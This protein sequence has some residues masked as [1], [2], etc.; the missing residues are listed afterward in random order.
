MLGNTPHK[1]PSQKTNIIA[2]PDHQSTL[3]PVQD[4]R[5][6]MNNIHQAE[7]FLKSGLNESAIPLLNFL[8]DIKIIQLKSSL[9]SRVLFNLGTAYLNIKK[10]N[11]AY[12]KFMSAHHLSPTIAAQSKAAMCLRALGGPRKACEHFKKSYENNQNIDALLGLSCCLSALKNFEK[13]SLVLRTALKIE[14]KNTI[15]LHMLVPL[16]HKV[17]A[18]RVL[19]PQWY[20]F[21]INDLAA[22]FRQ[23]KRLSKALIL[24]RHL[25]LARPKNQYALILIAQCYYE[26]NHYVA[27]LET[28]KKLREPF[29]VLKNIADH[30]KQKIHIACDD[31]MTNKM[32]AALQNMDKDAYK[33]SPEVHHMVHESLNQWAKHPSIRKDIGYLRF[34]TAEDRA[35]D[36]WARKRK[37]ALY[38]RYAGRKKI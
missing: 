29:F 6:M 36:E 15:I 26:M 20:E 24:F 21:A 9:Y 25:L 2:I 12:I 13:A 14:P 11:L 19:Q 31:L 7:Y 10:F 16:Y 1:K 30:L 8:A 38:P 22:Y 18:Y 34:F 27:A 32:Q 28:L 3:S 5:K 35:R 33:V 4:V 37:P 23:E 17:D